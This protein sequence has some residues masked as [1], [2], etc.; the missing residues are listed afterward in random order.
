MWNLFVVLWLVVDLLVVDLFVFY[1][2]LEFVCCLAIYG[3]ATD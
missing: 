3:L 1:S 2:L